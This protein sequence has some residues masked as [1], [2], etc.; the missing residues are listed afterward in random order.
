M[1]DPLVDADRL[2]LD[3]ADTARVLSISERSVWRLRAKG[4][5]PAVKVAGSIVRFR[6][7]DVEKYVDGL[8]GN[9]G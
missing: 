3:V 9:H 7:A 5:L 1:A 8:G 6:R 4:E 2:L